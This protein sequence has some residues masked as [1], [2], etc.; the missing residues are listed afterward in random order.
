MIETITFSG[1]NY[2]KFQSDGY[3]AQFA[4]P[5]AM[6][7]CHGVGI[8]VGCKKIE[9]AFPGAMIDLNN[10]LMMMGEK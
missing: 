6:H 4:I 7:V 9:L 10:S 3:A 5:Y 8:D 2:P 1:S